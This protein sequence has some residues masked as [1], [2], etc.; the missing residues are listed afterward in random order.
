M[1]GLAEAKDARV[2]F[3]LVGLLLVHPELAGTLIELAEATDTPESARQALQKQ[4]RA[5][6]YLQRMWRTKLRLALGE[7]PLIPEHF[8][9]G[10]GPAANDMH[11]KLGLQR[12]TEAS[13]FND[14][15]SYE[16][17]V[18]LICTQPCAAVDLAEL[19]GDA[20]P[21]M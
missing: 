17:V 18:E 4:Y 12:L 5:A 20:L 6:M 7:T 3:A 13:P 9:A 16:Q 11:G 1:L 8:V 19:Q 2:R 21:P 10:G 14:W 15:S